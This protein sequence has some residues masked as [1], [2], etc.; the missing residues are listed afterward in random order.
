MFIF[1]PLWLVVIVLS[2]CLVIASAGRESVSYGSGSDP[3][4]NGRDW[5]NR[6]VGVMTQ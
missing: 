3:E 5:D 1:G 2:R 6:L 4:K